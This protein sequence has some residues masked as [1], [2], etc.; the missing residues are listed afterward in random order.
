MQRRKHPY[1]GEVFCE[2][3]LGRAKGVAGGFF[4]LLPK[5]LP[6][7]LRKK[8]GNGKEVRRLE[9][10]WTKKTS[11][12]RR[13]RRTSGRTNGRTTG[14][15]IGIGRTKLNERL[16]SSPSS[17]GL[18]FCFCLFLL[19]SLLSRRSSLSIGT[20]L[21]IYTY[22]YTHTY[23]QAGVRIHGIHI[24]TYKHIDT[25]HKATASLSPTDGCAHARTYMYMEN[26]DTDST[27][28]T[29]L[30]TRAVVEI[31]PVM[32]HAG[33]AWVYIYTWSISCI[34]LLVFGV[35]RLAVGL[36]PGFSLP[37]PKPPFPVYNP[38]QARPVSPL[39]PGI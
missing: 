3:V 16:A 34:M 12:R 17:S 23:I 20:H 39:A 11:S 2:G 37:K 13:A 6:A 31:L 33:Y 14:T 9:K 4:G 27:G 24:R 25:S 32:A 8:A 29:C 10:D 26:S 28:F 5:D 1:F 15:G 18:A 22:I 19:S 38:L 36:R 35:N 30:S 21:F 7:G